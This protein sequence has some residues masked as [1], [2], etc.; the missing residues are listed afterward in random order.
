MTRGLPFFHELRV[1]SVA[2]SVGLL[3][4]SFGTNSGKVSLPRNRRKKSII[5]F[6]LD[7][8]VLSENE[9]R[10]TTNSF[11]IEANPRDLCLCNLGTQK[12]K[13]HFAKL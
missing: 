7:T 11:E 10:P 13:E 6:G 1:S 3:S 2:L 9:V 4:S 12:K 8:V 5:A